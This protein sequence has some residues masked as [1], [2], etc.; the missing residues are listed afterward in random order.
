MRIQNKFIRA[1][2]SG[3]DSFLKKA[4]MQKDL[5]RKVSAMAEANGRNVLLLRNSGL[6]KSLL[7]NFGPALKQE[8]AEVDLMSLYDVA[9]HKPSGA[10]IICNKGATLYSL[11]PRKRMAYITRHIGFALYIPSLGVEVVN[12]G[13]IGDVYGRPFALRSESACTPS[14]MFGSQRCN[15][16]HQWDVVK[17]TAAFLNELKPP[18]EAGGE[19]FED[20]VKKQFSLKN[21]RHLPLRR[22][23]MGFLLMHLDS[24]NG[25][26]SGHSNGEFVY[27]LFERASIRH[28][29]EYTAEQNFGRSMAQGFTALG[30]KPDPRSESNN[31]GYKISGII[32]DYLSTSKKVLFLC[33]NN[34]KITELRKQGY[35]VT[36]IALLGEINPA[37]F[38]E[39]KERNQEFGHRDISDKAVSYDEEFERLARSLSGEPKK[40]RPDNNNYERRWMRKAFMLARTKA[41][42]TDKPLV[43]T[44]I[45]KDGAI[46]GEGY[47]VQG[48]HLHA[49][50]MALR[51]AGARARGATLFTTLEPCIDAYNYPSCCTE[52]IKAGISCVV[53]A[54]IDPHPII[55]GRG[56]RTLE[57]AS[58]RTKMVMS[59]EGNDLIRGW[60]S[61]W[62]QGKV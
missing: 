37:G 17:E 29:A 32:L 40:N 47:G 52:I 1:F 26:G 7:E 56:I 34:K 41:K 28:R 46:I 30:L 10:V 9:V 21:N 18:E 45:V 5:F 58:I 22:G 2:G 35:D 3:V 36:R 14:F 24:Q 51:N 4:V 25:M 53:F 27:D 23:R 31:L 60:I 49:E 12:V 50:V 44:V 20:W 8:K 55:K 54:A 57:N 11:S 43:G 6:K 48:T 33:N 59:R 39:A 62:S 16:S 15:C 42:V 13:I 61:R 38:K 19:M